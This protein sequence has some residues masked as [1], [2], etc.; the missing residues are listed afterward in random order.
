MLNSLSLQLKETQS[1]FKE[2][3]LNSGW[4][5][6]GYFIQNEQDRIEH[7]Y[8]RFAACHTA[9]W[10]FINRFD[11]EQ[12]QFSG[13]QE[14]LKAHL[15]VVYAELLIN[16]QSAALVSEFIDDSTAV[17][18]LNESF[19][20]SEISRNT[21]NRL[22]NEIT[23]RHQEK[24]LQ[25]AW[26]LYKK[27]ASAQNPEWSLL[28]A[29]HPEYNEII[30]Q[31][32][33][34]YADTSDMIQ[35]ITKEEPGVFTESINNSLRH[36]FLANVIH[37][38]GQ[39][40]SDARYGIRSIRFKDIS[41]IKNPSAHLIKFSSD[42]KQM[43]YKHLKPGDIILTYT[44]GYMSDVFIPGVFKHGITHVGSPSERWE[45][46]LGADNCP[47][48]DDEKNKWIENISQDLLPDGR[49]ADVIEAVAE[50]VIFNN[51]EKIMDTHINRMLVLRPVL[52][53]SEKAE[54][55]AGVFAYLGDGYDFQFDFADASRQVC[56]EFIYRALNSKGD[57]HMTLTKRAGH[58]TLSADDI[59]IYSMG[60]IPDKFEFVLFAE[61][62][63]DS[64][65][66]MAIILLGQKAEYRIK[67]LFADSLPK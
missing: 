30:E 38:S 17:S 24:V 64:K 32:P 50:G 11:G 25:S 49:R 42:Q 65:N 18:K 39:E 8:F 51:L 27:D 45:A 23:S 1:A 20:L 22:L 66:H 63:P 41:R 62:K 47:L 54:F 28:I 57:I 13:T 33:S 34:L 43:I 19:Y 58:E 67:E 4:Q 35:K 40:I 48:P 31:I 37:W 16:Y 5:D 29:S 44:A 2:L 14:G 26:A 56:T 61:E 55:L 52:E 60:S 12:V 3:H 36:T 6:R 10:D 15:L 7:L 59:V 21:Y 9:L 46:G 53:D